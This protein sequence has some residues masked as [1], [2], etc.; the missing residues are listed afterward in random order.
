[1][2]RQHLANA[3]KAIVLLS[4]PVVDWYLALWVRN[5]DYGHLLSRNYEY[6]GITTEFLSLFGV[7][8]AVSLAI[9]VL[10]F[11]GGHGKGP[12]SDDSFFRDPGE[13]I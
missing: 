2:R 12:K 8:L 5:S 7:L 10:V 1:M 4:V 3:A 13:G 11:W 6:R 9:V